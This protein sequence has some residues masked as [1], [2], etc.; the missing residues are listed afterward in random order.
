MI[1]RESLPS[2]DPCECELKVDSST[3][4]PFISLAQKGT[5]A[6]PFSYLRLFSPIQPLEL[7]I[8]MYVRVLFPFISVHDSVNSVL[9]SRPG[10]YES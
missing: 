6:S 4:P 7:H 3:S 5:K 9:L 8:H 1:W 10:M 2:S